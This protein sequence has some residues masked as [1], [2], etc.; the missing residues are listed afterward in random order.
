MATNSKDHCKLIQTSSAA[1]NSLCDQAG[2]VLK[3][4]IHPVYKEIDNKKTKTK[5]HPPVA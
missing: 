1:N 5:Q 4:S 2:K 3:A